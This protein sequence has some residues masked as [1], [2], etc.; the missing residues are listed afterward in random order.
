MLYMAMY[1]ALSC[2][3]MYNHHFHCIFAHSLFLAQS[4]YLCL[5]LISHLV[6]DLVEVMASAHV[7]PPPTPHHSPSQESREGGNADQNAPSIGAAF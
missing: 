3:S 1:L 7:H 4:A 6:L 2:L 5:S